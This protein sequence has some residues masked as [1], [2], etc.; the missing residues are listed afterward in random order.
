M[1]YLDNNATT[2]PSQ[3]VV[4]AML[5]YLTDCFF[6]P[7]ASNTAFTGVDKPRQQAAVK[8]RSS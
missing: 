2:Q 1:I 5:P 6:N 4:E 7:T 3:G 8:W